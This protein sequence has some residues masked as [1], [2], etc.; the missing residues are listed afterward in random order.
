MNVKIDENRQS[1]SIATFGIENINKISKL[2]VFIYG[3]NGI[4]LEASKNLVLT[5]IKSLTIY[6]AN[7]CKSEDLSWNFFLDDKDVDVRRKDENLISRLK[8]L[9]ENVEILIEKDLEK[10]LNNNDI[11]VIADI[12]NSQDIYNINDFCRQNHKG[13]IYAALFGLAGF[14]FSDFGNHLI[15]DENGEE[16][17]KVFISSIT[18][19]KRE[20]KLLFSVK[21]DENDGIDNEK[22]V[23]FKEIEG[24]E[25]LNKLE[26][27][28]IYKENEFIYFI[29]Y[30]QDLSDYI[31][32]GIIEEVKIPKQ[33]N[34]ISYKEYMKNPKK[35]CELD[36]S[37][38]NINCLLHCL[39]L[40]IQKFFDIYKSLPD[41]NNEKQAEEIVIFSKEFYFSFKNEGNILF[42]NSNIFDYIFIKTL[43]LFSKI[44]LPTDS[45]F[46][47]GVL[48]QEIL[49]FS[50]LYKPLN[51]ILYY[52]NFVTIENLKK[53]DK[54]INYL[55][56]D[57]Y[58]YENIIYGRNVIK[59]LKKLNIFIIGAGAL[60]CEIMKI[61]A[62]MGAS[63][64]EN[65]N[66]I[67]TDNDSIELSNLNRQFFFKEKHIG[68]NKAIICCEE[69]KK[70][71]SEINCIPIDKLV[72]HN[73]EDF[74][75]DDFWSY[76]DIV[77]LAVDNVSARRYIDKKCTTY[78]I[79]LIEIGTQ[80]V[81]ANSSLIIPNLTSCYN[82]IK[83]N[84]KKEIPQCTLKYY[85]ITNVHCIEYARQ[86]FDDFF[87]YNIKDTLEYIKSKSYF[88]NYNKEN[89]RKLI[90]FKYIIQIFKNKN[91]DDCLNLAINE[92]YSYFNYNI[93]DLLNNNPPDSK[94]PDGSLFWNGD[95]R[96]PNEINF[97]LND[98]NQV[99]FIYYYAYLIA[100]N[101]KI[102]IK[103]KNMSKEYIEKNLID[104]K[105]ILNEEEIIRQSKILNEENIKEIAKIN[106]EEWE[107]IEYDD[108]EKDNDRNHH[109]EFLTSFANL[110]AK[111]YRIEQ[112]D[113]I[114]VKLIA[115]KIIPAIST[116]TSSVCGYILSQIYILM[117]ESYTIK[118]LRTIFF[119]FTIPI[120]S[121]TQPIKVS[122]IQN[123]KGDNSE[124]ETRVPYDFTV[125]DKI[126]IE[127]N[128][129]TKQLTE[130]LKKIAGFDFEF[131]GIYTIDDIPL[132][133][134]EKD[135]NKYI[136]D[137]YFK[138]VP[139][140]YQNNVLIEKMRIKNHNNEFSNIYLKYY[141]IK[142][143]IIMV[144]FPTIKY[145][146][147]K[148][149]IKNN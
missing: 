90:I 24:M 92:F 63:T 9:N 33:M 139:N 98:D 32:G 145:H 48:S 40:S 67:L 129:S 49:K 36:Y 149:Q 137:I 96:M 135:M 23:R 78:N 70:I 86:K 141:G 147:K 101:L 30:N 29:N 28:Q 80:G 26:P 57:R 109:I 105:K 61:L 1:R 14:I 82:N 10:A 13:F 134:E 17:Q 77:I 123:K 138:K 122:I 3:V 112:S 64:E 15:L 71:N 79:K 59:Q 56:K 143:E 51:Q 35:I 20:K 126:E 76:L 42:K 132:I 11:I 108:F 113:K 37:K 5:G 114:L 127:G 27:T 73:S 69:A 4:S 87:H 66:I 104:F 125:W 144:I 2:K 95:K 19:N 45:S 103:D 94:K 121:I 58:Y 75:T 124:V 91:F 46:L 118:N 62:L 97:N 31:R 43:A 93:R 74:F 136:E 117:R 102:E 89:W 128:I 85:P 88:D 107:N 106:I 84:P 16:I 81:K 110:R 50:G 65:S 148:N 53:D 83:R 119:N 131:D 99:D 21:K 130:K 7:F 140:E 72:N 25:E 100:K 18:Q 68:K 38:N 116:T 47:G 6:D 111:N 44:Q 22:F 41:I 54:E 8:E 146:Y 52:N 55:K 60:G 115:G 133:Q 39:I 12:K 34:Y 142:D 120:F